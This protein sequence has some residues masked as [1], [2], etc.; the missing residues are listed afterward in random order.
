MAKY[1]LIFKKSV[2]KDLR[3]IPNS[4]VSRILKKIEQLM[5]DPRPQ[6]YTRLTGNEKYRIRHGSYRII[7]QIKDTV[8]VVNVIK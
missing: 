5:D 3:V 1:S 6:G 7:Y 8:L 2:A 4:D